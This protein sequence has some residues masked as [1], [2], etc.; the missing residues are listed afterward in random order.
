MGKKNETFNRLEKLYHEIATN[1]AQA[2]VK[3]LEL[4]GVAVAD[5]TQEEIQEHVFGVLQMKT[6]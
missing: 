4:D 5:S 1:A 6:L 2:A 3:Q